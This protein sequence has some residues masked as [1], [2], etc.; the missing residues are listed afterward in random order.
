MQFTLTDEQARLRQTLREFA[1]DEIE[2]VATDLD[3]RGEYPDEILAAL[4]DQGDVGTL[5]GEEEGG[6][7]YGLVVYALVIEGLSASR[8]AV[9]SAIDVHVG[10]ATL[11]E[12]FGTEDLT[13][14]SLAG[15]ATF[16]TVGAF[17]LTEPQAGSDS[18]STR[19][20]AERDGDVPGSTSS[21]GARHSTASRTPVGRSG[22]RAVGQPPEGRVPHRASRDSQSPRRAG[23][24]GERDRSERTRRRKRWA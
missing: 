23:E 11:L 1:R 5:L 15:M 14:E 9:P 16:D 10:A 3:R 13:D 22:R 24:N 6:P 4:G 19:T 8:M 7:D 18:A 21:G 2:P 12:E 20:R 17:G